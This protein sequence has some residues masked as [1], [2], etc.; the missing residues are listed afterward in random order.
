MP[1]IIVWPQRIRKP[2]TTDV[3]CSTSD[4]YPTLLEIAGVK[5]PHQIEPLDGIS[6]LPLIEGRMNERP[7]PIA[8]WHN[9]RRTPGEKEPYI[10]P[11][12][13]KGWWRTFSNFK[14]PQPLANGFTGHAVLIDGRYKLHKLDAGRCELYDL[15]ADPAETRDLAEEKPELVARMKA[16]LEQWQASVERSLAGQDY[17]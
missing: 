17:K 16:E 10:D 9:R 13:Q 2:F 14:H 11:E 8:F 1:G 7:K 3:P 5:L 6:L 12:L 4:I 15:A